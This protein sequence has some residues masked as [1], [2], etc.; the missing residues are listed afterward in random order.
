MNSA[1][2]GVGGVVRRKLRTAQSMSW[3]DRCLVAEAVL[4]LGA[5]RATLLLLPFRW[6]RPWLTV[7]GPG[8][9]SDRV[10]VSRVRRAIDIA[11]RNVPFSAV[12]LPQAMAAKAMLARRGICSSVCIGVAR[13]ADGAMLL[14]A[15]LE[16]GGSI[17]TGG[18]GRLA[19]TQVARFS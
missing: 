14:H 17:V 15:W 8:D 16:A 10:L 4:M 18:A 9:A 5:A 11:S 13:G 3:S 19:V 2:A 1:D 12:C 7:A 6:F